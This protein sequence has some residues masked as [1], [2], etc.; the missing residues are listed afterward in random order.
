MI[1]KLRHCSALLVC[2]PVMFSLCMGC[3]KTATADSL[4]DLSPVERSAAER[5]EPSDRHRWDLMRSIQVTKAVSAS[6]RKEIDK[7]ADSK[8]SKDRK[9]FAAIVT[10][11]LEVKAVTKAEALD[12]IDRAIKNSAGEPERKAWQTFRANTDSKF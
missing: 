12:W 8:E 1:L 9:S 5:L 6:Q 3:G 4:A 11:T 2:L 7:M 10:A